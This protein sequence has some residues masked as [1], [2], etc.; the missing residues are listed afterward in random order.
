V[1]VYW[2]YPESG[3]KHRKTIMRVLDLLGCGAVGPTTEAALDATPG[4]IRAFL[5]FLRRHG[6]E[7][8]PDAPFATRVAEHVTGPSLG[9]SPSA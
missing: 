7:V 5:G 4:A 2:L 9:T 6:R 8:D 3:P 1:S